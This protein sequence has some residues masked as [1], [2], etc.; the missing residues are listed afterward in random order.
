LKMPHNP[1]PFTPKQ[2]RFLKILRR[3]LIE[4][5]DP[6]KETEDQ[7]DY[8]FYIQHTKKFGDI[9]KIRFKPN[10]LSLKQEIMIEAGYKPLVEKPG[11]KAARNG[12]A[13]AWDKQWDNLIFRL[14]KSG[15]MIAVFN[16]MFTEDGQT[17]SELITLVQQCIDPGKTEG[18]IAAREKRNRLEVKSY[19]DDLLEME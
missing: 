5:R 6:S 2:K 15:R 4:I 18:R 17:I 1:N 13:S 3:K 11:W 8:E 19:I 16:Q 7:R 10:S 9:P 12:T 14:V